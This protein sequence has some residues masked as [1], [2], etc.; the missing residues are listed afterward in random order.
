MCGL[1]LLRF[2]FNNYV[3]HGLGW[4]HY[5]LRLLKHEPLRNVCRLLVV[6][7]TNAVI[8]DAVVLGT[9]F[10]DRIHLLDSRDSE[11]IVLEA[12]GR[13][14]QLAVVIVGVHSD[15]VD[16][17]LL[18][19]L[20]LL[21]LTYLLSSLAAEADVAAG[22]PDLFDEDVAKLG[23]NA[24]HDQGQ[25]VPAHVQADF[26]VVDK[27][28]LRE[29]HSE[30]DHEAEL[31]PQLDSLWANPSKRLLQTHVEDHPSRSDADEQKLESQINSSESDCRSK[32][33]P[34]EDCQDQIGE[35]CLLSSRGFLLHHLSLSLVVD[36]L[37]RRPV[38]L[39]SARVGKAD[40]PDEE[41]GHEETQ[42]VRKQHVGVYP[43][44]G[45]LVP[46]VVAYR[47]ASHREHECPVD[48]EV[49]ALSGLASFEGVKVVA[50]GTLR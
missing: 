7:I 8:V 25:H 13:L 41:G 9:V 14:L 45:A 27:V 11:V 42:T 50:H 1:L 4:Y 10:T 39:T 34:A 35:S 26:R 5:A 28:T 49:E 29:E 46:L 37:W 44:V 21:P 43:F 33:D 32:P 15:A 16:V 23:H 3:S 6:A 19:N 17:L 40:A 38:F 48:K 20:R 30:E 47:A 18:D 36:L 2:L 24:Q 12:L 31:A 22:E